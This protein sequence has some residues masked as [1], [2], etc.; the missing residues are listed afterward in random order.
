MVVIIEDD[1]ILLSLLLF[2]KYLFIWL[3]QVLVVTLRTF[4]H[5]CMWDL[6]PWA[7]IEPRPPALG[8]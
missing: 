5:F 1:H 3:G 4:D 2:K 7:G 8:V 6:A